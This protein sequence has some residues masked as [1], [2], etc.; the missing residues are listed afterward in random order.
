MLFHAV[1]KQGQTN[2]SRQLV[3]SRI[4]ADGDQYIIGLADALDYLL[5]GCRVHDFSSILF[6]LFTSVGRLAQQISISNSRAIGAPTLYKGVAYL[7]IRVLMP[8]IK[9]A[10]KRVKITA[11][12]RTRNA[13]TKRTMRESLK[14]F[15]KAVASKKSA[16]I[17]EAQRQAV[18]TVDIAL[19][20]AVIHANKAARIKARMAAQAKAAGVKPAKAV[21]KKAAPAK[22]I[23]TKKPAT[24]KAPSKSKK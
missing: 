1:K 20:K 19:K 17:S 9:S 6:I 16:D 22:K 15:S 24:K 13:Q 4:V 5:F 12:A 23:V 14:A 3:N 8:I 2:T 18:S 21:T 7:Y 10:R 11:K